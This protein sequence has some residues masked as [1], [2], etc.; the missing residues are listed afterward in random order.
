LVGIETVNLYTA[1]VALTVLLM[2]KGGEI[3][4]IIPRSFCNGSYYRPF[5]NLILRTCSIRQLHLFESRKKAFQ[6]D[7][8]LQ[9]NIISHLIKG[10][11]QDHV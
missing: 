11:P 2:A 1:F 5:R 8:V 3:V 6:D 10:D 9:E 4:A 7:D